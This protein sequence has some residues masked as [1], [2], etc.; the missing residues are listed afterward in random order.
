MN[1]DLRIRT[2]RFSISIM[3]WA[4]KFNLSIPQ[5]VISYQLVKCGILSNRFFVLTEGREVIRN[6]CPNSILSSTKLTN[7]VFGLR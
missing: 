1:V 2:K 3:D 7:A 5:K 4:E 6:S